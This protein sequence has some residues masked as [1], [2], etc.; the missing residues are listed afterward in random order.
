MRSSTVS[1]FAAASSCPTG[2]LSIAGLGVAKTATPDVKSSMKTLEALVTLGDVK[3]RG[4]TLLQGFV[5]G[6]D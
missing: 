6:D 2:G 5:G 3:S 4:Q 1:S